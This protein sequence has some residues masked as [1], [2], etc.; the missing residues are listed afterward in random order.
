MIKVL[1]VFSLFHK[2]RTDEFP[3]FPKDKWKT[4]NKSGSDTSPNQNVNLTLHIGILNDE[5]HVCHTNTLGETQLIRQ[6]T[7]PIGNEISIGWKNDHVKDVITHK[8]SNGAKD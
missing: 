6:V 3:Y 1:R 2:G 5:R 7:K 8:K 4:Q